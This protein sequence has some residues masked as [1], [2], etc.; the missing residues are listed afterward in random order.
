VLIRARLAADI[1]GATRMDRPEDTEV[2]PRTGKVYVNLTNNAKREPDQTDAANP[3]PE[4][5]FGHVIEITPD[6]GDH[7]ADAFTWDI[8]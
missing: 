1:L 3:R 6:E 7:A 4:N 5:R 2:N 8:L